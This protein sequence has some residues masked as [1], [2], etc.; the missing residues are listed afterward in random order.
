LLTPPEDR[1]RKADES[2]PV[3]DDSDE[4]VALTYQANADLLLEYAPFRNRARFSP[5]PSSGAS[6]RTPERPGQDR[7]HEHVERGRRE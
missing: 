7:D 6:R 5:A 4:D 3:S 1:R 2:V